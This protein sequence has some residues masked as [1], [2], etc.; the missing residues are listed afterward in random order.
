MASTHRQPFICRSPYIKFDTKIIYS[1]L[2]YIILILKHTKISCNFTIIINLLL[3]IMVSTLICIL[4]LMYTCE[5]ISEVSCEKL[6]SFVWQYISTTV[7]NFVNKHWVYNTI[8][9]YILCTF[10]LCYNNISIFFCIFMY[11]Y[12]WNIEITLNKVNVFFFGL[13]FEKKNIKSVLQQM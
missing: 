8:S 9:K 7:C 3:L 1:P 2:V 13:S 5:C 4:L 6:P 11:V 10:K 12:F